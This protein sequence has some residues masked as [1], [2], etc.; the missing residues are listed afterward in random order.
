MGVL[1]PDRARAA[2][3]DRLADRFLQYAHD[4][5]DDGAQR[6]MLSI[7]EHLRDVLHSPGNGDLATRIARTC[8]RL[9]LR[10]RDAEPEARAAIVGAVRYFLETHDMRRDDERQGL[11]DDLRVVDYVAAAVAPDLAP[12]A[13]A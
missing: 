11:D 1:D 10:H 2:L 13:G 8:K 5:G 4:D 3:G 6:L 12:V 9:L 7:D